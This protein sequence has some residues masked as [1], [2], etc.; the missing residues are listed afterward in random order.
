[1]WPTRTAA[2]VAGT[3][4]GTRTTRTEDGWDAFYPNQGAL[5]RHEGFSTSVD[6]LSVTCNGP[7]GRRVPV[8]AP[9]TGDQSSA[10]SSIV[11][12]RIRFA[13][14]LEGPTGG[15]S[16]RGA[17]ALGPWAKR[18]LEQVGTVFHG[19]RD[20]HQ[21]H[22]RILV[23]DV[24]VDETQPAVTRSHTQTRTPTRPRPG[25]RDRCSDRSATCGCGAA[26]RAL[27]SLGQPR[28]ATQSDR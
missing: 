8:E 2:V 7:K 3:E 18:G 16:G 13:D 1:M 4:D 28:N 5:E 25:H 26:A 19:L 11:R 17:G 20:M 12:V 23:G 24:N 21:Q 22:F 6:S 10:A 14:A 15:G 27:Q 9:N